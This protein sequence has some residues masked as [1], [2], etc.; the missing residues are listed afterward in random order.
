MRSDFRWRPAL[1][2][3]ALLLGLPGTAQ[4][5]QRPAHLEGRAQLELAPGAA[6][7]QVR[8]H[9]ARVSA[10][11]I[12][13]PNLANIT[14]ELGADAWLQIDAD[15]GVL[16]TMVPRGRAI[17]GEL[18]RFALEFVARHVDVLAPGSAAGDLVLVSDQTSLGVRTIGFVQHHRGMPIVGAQLSLSFIGNRLVAVRSTAL[19]QVSVPVRS[20]TADV[21]VIG[22]SARAWIASDFATGQRQRTRVDGS[23][24]SPM[25]L[26]IVGQGGAIE[27]REVVS[28]EVVLDAPFGRWQVYADAATGQPIARRSLVHW[29][30]LQIN[31]WQRT[32]LGPRTD[33]PASFLDVM[34]AGQPSTTDAA[35]QLMVAAP[36]TAVEFG[37]NS[38]LLTVDNAAGATA[39]VSTLLDVG[40]SFVWDLGDDPEQ[41]A[42]LSAYVHA[43]IV[44]A[45]VRAIDPTFTPLDLQ[46][47]VTVNIA[48]VCNAFADQNTL[49]FFL[50]G[51]GCQNTALLGDVVYHEYGHIVH[52]LGLQAGVGLF[53]G[54]VSEGA[55]DYLSATITNDSAL[56]P[57]FFLNNN[58]PLRELDPPNSEWQWPEDTGEVHDE[59]RIL[60]GTLWDLRELMI[61]KY[62]QA[63][64]VR[65][66]DEI[67]L[68]GMQR[69]VDMQSWYLEALIT[70]DDDGDLHNGTPDACEINAAFGVHG[71]YQPIGAIVVEQVELADGSREVTVE[72]PTNQ[73]QLCA[74]DI[75]PSAVLRHRPRSDDTFNPNPDPGTEI[76]FTEVGPG[77]MRAVIPPQPDHTV[78]QFKVEFDWGNGTIAARPDNRADEWYEYYSGPTQ[79]IWCS[80]FEQ[81]D[82]WMLE[83]E[84][85]IGAPGGGGGDPE[86]A[87]DGGRVA[88]VALAFPGIYEPWTASRIVSPTIDTSGHEVVRLQYRRWLTIEDGFFDQAWISAN[89]ARVWQ[90]HT[91]DWGDFATVHHRDHE[92]RFHDIDLSS[93]VAADSQLRLEFGLASD[94]GLE[95]GGWN[96]D[97]VCVVGIGTSEPPPPPPTGHCGDGYV[98]SHEQCD[99][100]NLESGDGCSAGCLFEQEPESP[101]EPIDDPWDPDGRGCDCT[102]NEDA[103]PL[104]ALGLLALGLLALRRR[105][106]QPLR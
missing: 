28:L 1:I 37:P 67:W 87:Y 83:G 8:T 73:Q 34:V 85:S 58:D 86:A 96:I 2:G 102:T 76:Q 97:S 78:T 11:T 71:L 94:G 31:T 41:D 39:S 38:P 106:V 17:A 13:A 57:G 65:K 88:G 43:Q 84:W 98:Q 69:S 19:P 72:H 80:D 42:Q 82:G 24:S 103:Q 100:G 77:I 15:T 49:N 89:D 48:D 47:I 10:S 70:N 55:S 21:G 32:P 40:Q 93:V 22:E 62:G 60:G 46:T 23:S 33:F 36:G 14:A 18:D 92:W 63:L 105:R 30:D 91:S 101:E 74:L 53:D 99:D 79:E 35:G 29:A 4:A 27:Y 50:A 9:R 51:G 61:E 3:L 52:V 104:P 16:A 6:R 75:D 64:G 56:S 59:G 66:T 5:I 68:G 26:P 54:A 25:I 7:T 20:K 12:A 81:D 45:Y 95:F 44:K 90:N